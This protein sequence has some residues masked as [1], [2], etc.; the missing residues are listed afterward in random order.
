M[1]H[2]VT[3]GARSGKSSFAEEQVLAMC[4]EKVAEDNHEDSREGTAP[5]YLA[6]AQAFDQEMQQRIALHQQDRVQQNWQLIECPVA[7]VD[8]LD[9]IADGSSVLIDCLT[10]WLN[11]LLLEVDGL[12]SEQQHDM[13][14]KQREAL[15]AAFLKHQHR[16]DIVIVTNEVG[17]G[18]VP[19]GELSRLFVDH[20]GWVNQA[21]AKIADEVTLV[22]SGIPVS[23]KG[24]VRG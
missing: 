24:A 4:V 9:S 1:I 21:T 10:L 22:V 19:L 7:L 12:A 2:L 5:I 11:N 3:G 17:S 6:T 20:A 23:I 18:I 14:S 13:L 8:A 15:V 16:L